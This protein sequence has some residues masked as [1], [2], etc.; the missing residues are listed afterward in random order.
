VPVLVLYG[1]ADFVTSLEESRSLVRTIDRVHRGRARLQVMPMD[2]EF[3]FF[4]SQ[5][6]AWSAEQQGRPGTVYPKLVDVVDKFLR[7][8]RPLGRPPGLGPA[9]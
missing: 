7:G 8:V 1:S 9:Q 4:A 3:Q 5:K 6:A 2:H